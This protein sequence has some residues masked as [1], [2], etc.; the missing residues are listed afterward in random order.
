MISFHMSLVLW[1]G[2]PLKNRLE[3][4]LAVY[5]FLAEV[6]HKKAWQ[7]IS[8]GDFKQPEL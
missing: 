7:K 5:S 8:Q 6:R 1:E 2:A 3:R 4:A